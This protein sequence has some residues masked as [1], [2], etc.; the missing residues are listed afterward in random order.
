M[1]NVFSNAKEMETIIKQHYKDYNLKGNIFTIKTRE[2]RVKELKKMADL[3]KKLGHNSVYLTK[4]QTGAGQSSVGRTVVD[5]KY[6]IDCKPI[7]LPGE[8]K[9]SAGKAAEKREVNSLKEQITKFLK[10]P[11]AGDYINLRVNNVVYE[12]A[13]CVIIPDVSP[14]PKADFA[15][16]D[17][18]GKEVFWI[19]YKDG[20]GPKGFQQYAGMSQRVEKFISSHKETLNFVDAVK[21]TFPDGVPGST[22][23]CRMINDNTLKGYAVFGKSF[24]PGRNFSRDNVQMFAQGELKLSKTGNYYEIKA[25][26]H[27][28]FN[29][30]TPTG[31][32]YDLMFLAR[33]GDRSDYGIPG[34]RMFIYPEGG[35]SNKTFI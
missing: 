35:R 15:L 3:F 31:D 26:N 10:E 17:T 9:E 34:T 13:D 20:M 18:K 21:S 30:K 27:Y 4:G 11:G 1:A 8:K 19:S 6:K 5:N 32:G 25:T 29:P 7:L 22:N 28:G 14:A 33:K 23:I 24:A 16:C 12:V 2:D